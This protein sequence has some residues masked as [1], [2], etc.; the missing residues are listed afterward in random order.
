[1]VSFAISR[2]ELE[3]SDAT[4]GQRNATPIYKC[5]KLAVGQWSGRRTAHMGRENVTVVC[6]MARLVTREECIESQGVEVGSN[7]FTRAVT[8]TLSSS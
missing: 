4:Y 5:S 7:R 6:G 2:W 8:Y 1:M 3:V